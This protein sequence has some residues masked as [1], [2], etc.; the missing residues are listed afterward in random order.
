MF[1]FK[2]SSF[3]CVALVVCFFTAKAQTLYT[4]NGLVGNSTNNNLGVNINN[5]EFPFHVNGGVKIGLS[6]SNADRMN[7][8]LRFGDGN[9]VRMGEFEYDD[10]LSFYA[11][12]HNFSQ[13]NVGIGLTGQN[14]YGGK[15]NIQAFA[16]DY[17]RFFKSSSSGF[18][19]LQNVISQNGLVF[20]NQSDNGQVTANVFSL[21]GAGNVGIGTAS[22]DTKL[23]V[24]GNIKMTG[25]SFVI[26]TND[27]SFQGNKPGQRALFHENSTNKDVLL[28]NYQGEFEDGTQ[29]Q[30]NLSVTGSLSVGNVS[31]NNTEKSQL[32]MTGNLRILGKIATTEICV[33]PN[34][35]WCDYV[36]EESYPL[37]PLKDLK[38]YIGHHKHLPEV[39]TSEEVKRDGVNLGEINVTYLKKIEELTLYILQQQQQLDIIQG[40][41]KT[42]A[43]TKR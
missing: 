15:L 32:D 30:S 12:Q 9:Y 26:G 24:A 40:Q 18:W 5:P 39:P 38:Q 19:G 13:G 1:I 41:L 22:P 42:L 36:F 7:S 11:Y 28:V 23:E 3:A 37:M 16:G 43:T 2:K 14:T 34:S 17:L 31:F 35:N 25:P 21:T 10:R 33:N 27:G 6:T 4:P 20:Y 8:Q 29:I